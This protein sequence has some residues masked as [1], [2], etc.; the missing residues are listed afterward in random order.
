MN[1]Y[2]PTVLVDTWLFVATSNH[3]DLHYKKAVVRRN[4][5]K[6]FGSMAIAQMY[7]E[8]NT[9]NKVA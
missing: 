4:I 6:M 9:I 2:P 1:K 7:I 8:Q 3:P 5:E